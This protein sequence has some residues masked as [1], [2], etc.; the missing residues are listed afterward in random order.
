MPDEFQK[1]AVEHHRPQES[2]RL[3][4]VGLIA[5]SCKMADAVGF[6]AIPFK[7]QLSPGDFLRTLSPAIQ[8]RFPA[9]LDML[10]RKVESRIQVLDP[11]P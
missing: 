4:M 5:L 11:T 3:D 7:D 2:D 6:A 1:V 9:D 8:E 10:R